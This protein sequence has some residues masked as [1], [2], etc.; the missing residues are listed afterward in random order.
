MIHAVLQ[1]ALD[2][3]ETVLDRATLLDI[4]E[5]MAMSLATAGHDGRP[6]V[7]VVLLRGWSYRG[8]V[9]YTNSQSRKGEQLAA[10]PYAALCLYWDGL[11]E[12]VR[13]EGAVEDVT[14]AEDT[15]YWSHRPRENQVTAV[16]SMQS[17]VLS[18][19]ELL[20]RQI[21]AIDEQYAGR[22]VPRPSHWHGY[23]VI[24][25]RI[26]FWLGRE[27]RMHERTVFERREAEWATYLLYP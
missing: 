4:R 22:P 13:I 9:F 7:R 23:R 12:Q 27:G 16:A 25:D 3:F 1:Q 21:R 10:N 18:D 26:E 6:S 8:F 11:H 15:A 19:R 20:E 2:R 24:P 14:E 17:Q 5:P